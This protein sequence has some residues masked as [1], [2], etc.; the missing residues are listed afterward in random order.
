[1][2]FVMI[3]MTY[4]L[5]LQVLDDKWDKNIEEF[6]VINITGFKLIDNSRKF[7]KDILETWKLDTLSVR[8]PKYFLIFLKVLKFLGGL[9]RSRKSCLMRRY[10]RAV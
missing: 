2:L 6:N 7:V 8:N 5:W 10:Y 4:F 3:C 9:W 1:M